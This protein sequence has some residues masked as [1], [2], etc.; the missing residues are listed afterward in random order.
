MFVNVFRMEICPDPVIVSGR[1][2]LARIHLYS[3]PDFIAKGYTRPLDH[4]PAVNLT[5]K[6]KV[7]FKA[8]CR[9][10]CFLPLFFMVTR[11]GGSGVYQVFIRLKKKN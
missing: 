8:V 3:L 5:P 1:N 10:L 7:Y 6:I 2:M 9:S 4:T 11:F